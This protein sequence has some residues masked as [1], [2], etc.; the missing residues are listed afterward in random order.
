MHPF[1]PQGQNISCKYE[2]PLRRGWLTIALSHKILVV[3]YFCPVMPLP[4]SNSLTL[5]LIFKETLPIYLS[6]VVIALA[7]L[8]IDLLLH[9]SDIVEI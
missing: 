6:L 9:L 5:G 2:P 8:L 4:G 3:Q 7:T 1:S